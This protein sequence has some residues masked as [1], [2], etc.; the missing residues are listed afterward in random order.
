MN[1]IEV[2]ITKLA[3]NLWSSIVTLAIG[4]SNGKIDVYN[5]E[6]KYITSLDSSEVHKHELGFSYH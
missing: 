2:P 6:D 1:I 3:H 4:F 5:A